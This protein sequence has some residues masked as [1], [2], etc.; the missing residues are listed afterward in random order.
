M[1]KLYILI[2]TIL[3][4]T[5]CTSNPA[6]MDNFTYTYSME[7]TNN[8]KI[9]FQ[10]NSDSTYK[11]TQYNFFF[12]NFEKKKKPIYSSGTLNNEQFSTFRKLLQQSKIEHMKDSYGFKN[13]T[14][15]YSDIIYMIELNRNGESKYVSINSN[16]ANSFPEEFT[17]LIKYTNKIISMS[18]KE[19]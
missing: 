5:S 4:I 19:K 12:D 1:N 9:E 17:K 7:N 10:L 2:A 13:E 15:S 18:Q 3:A 8:F 11:I 14:T 16:E 6:T